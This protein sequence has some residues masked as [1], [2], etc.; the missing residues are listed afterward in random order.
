MEMD[1]T[2]QSY[3]DWV[4]SVFN[5]FTPWDED[6]LE[7][8]RQSDLNLVNGK[9][10]TLLEYIRQLCPDPDALKSYTVEQVEQ[11]LWFLFG[12][13][14]MIPSVKSSLFDLEGQLVKHV[15]VDDRVRTIRTIYYL[16]AGYVADLPSPQDNRVTAIDMIWDQVSREFW[17]DCRESRNPNESDPMYVLAQATALLKVDQDRLMEL[18]GDEQATEEYLK[19]CG[20]DTSRLTQAELKYDDLTPSEKRLIDAVVETIEHAI[21]LDSQRCQLAALQG[22][23]HSNHP[24]K[25][26]IA[27][28][29]LET[30]R[31]KLPPDS[32]PWIETCATDR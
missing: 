12:S 15:S 20:V 18:D 4:V 26:E 31:S 28:S 7:W 27:K 11:G 19:S 10:T 8:Y 23:V 30:N 9:P 14:A 5:H 16:Y 25:S 2:A 29:Y 3:E 13:N 24:R 17:S 22:L 1:L 21:S 32:I 6:E